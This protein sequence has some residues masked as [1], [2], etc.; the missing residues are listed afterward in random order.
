MNLSSLTGHHAIDNAIEQ[1]I[2]LVDTS[3]PTAQFGYYLHGSWGTHTA[4][5]QSD[6]DILAVTRQVLSPEHRARAKEIASAISMATKVPLDFHLHSVE[7][8]ISDPYIDLG[9]TGVFI[10]GTDIR[11]SLPR[12]SLDLLAREAVSITCQ[13]ITE[14]RAC[15]HVQWPLSHPNPADVC[16]G[17]FTPEETPSGLAKMLTWIASAYVAGTYGYAPTSAADALQTLR[18]EKDPYSTW[19]D[20]ALVALG[21]PSATSPQAA[22]LITLAPFLSLIHI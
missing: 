4:R 22:E 6:V 18:A 15:A 1:L 14:I 3:L 11:S 7:T 19:L 2:T 17:R 16:F 8:L 13:Y 5:P 10:T 9:R 21:I 20:E 12:P